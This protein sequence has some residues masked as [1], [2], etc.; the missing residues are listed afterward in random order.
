MVLCMSDKGTIILETRGEI[1][2][3]PFLIDWLHFL[4]KETETSL[5]TEAQYKG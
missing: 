3:F 5:L 2:V 4:I 1:S